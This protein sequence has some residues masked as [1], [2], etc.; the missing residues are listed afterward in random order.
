MSKLQTIIVDNTEISIFTKNSEDYIC[1]TDMVGAKGDDSRAADVIKNWIRTRATIEFLGTWESMY[2]PNFKVV[3]FDHFRKEAGLPTFVLSVSNWVEKTNAIGIF[4]KSGKYGGTYAHKD[5]AF[6]F[7]AAISPVFKLYLYKEY[8][9]LKEVENNQYNLEW[10][11]KRILTKVNHTIHTDAV[12]KHIIPKSSLPL[13]KQGI[14]YAN[15]VDLLNLALYGYTAKDWRESNP[16]LHSQG[17]N[18]RDFSS[19]NELLVMSNLEVMNAEM[20]KLNTP[21]ETR[22]AILNRMVKEQLEQLAKVDIIKSVRKQSKTTYIEA[23]DMTGEEIE[24]Q[25]N[26]SILETSKQNLLEFKKRKG[27]N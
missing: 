5:I 2:N 22:F 12:Q 27:I 26:K 17:K 4:S 8:Q 13:N 10:D 18:M 7:G 9:R 11:V 23:K 24:D 19:I 15:E 16:E 6:E 25:A 20:I 14:E 3:E 1:L 21:K